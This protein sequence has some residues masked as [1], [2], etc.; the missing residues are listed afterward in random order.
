MARIS[1][2]EC[3]R[4]ISETADSCPK[5]GYKLVREEAVKTK[6]KRQG[7]QMLCVI[8]VVLGFCVAFMIIWEVIQNNSKTPSLY[9]D[10]LEA[11]RHLV[12]CL[13][14]YKTEVSCPHVGYRR[15]VKGHKYYWK[16]PKG[17]SRRLKDFDSE[18]ARVKSIEMPH[19]RRA[20]EAREARQRA[21]AWVGT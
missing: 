5:C 7:V 21:R 9:Q 17:D 15:D 12:N 19:E 8:V 1:C 3:K 2:P 11:K 6:K 4:Q 16:F 13:S 18:I 10:S 20:R 14:I